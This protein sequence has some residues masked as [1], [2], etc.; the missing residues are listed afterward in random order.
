MNPVPT[1]NSGTTSAL[2][3]YSQPKKMTHRNL[4]RTLLHKRGPK[5]SKDVLQSCYFF[6]FG[7]VGLSDDVPARLT[8]GPEFIIKIALRMHGR[9]LSEAILGG[10]GRLNGTDGTEGRNGRTD[11]RTDPP[12][13]HTCPSTTHCDLAVFPSVP[14]RKLMVT[15]RGLMLEMTRLDGAPGSSANRSTRGKTNKN[16]SVSLRPENKV[17]RFSRLCD[18][19]SSAAKSPLKEHS[20]SPQGI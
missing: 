13:T 18:L 11:G 10:D 2:I 6:L 16:P 4:N 14:G 19:W 15:E 12:Q 9:R 3:F 1:H 20:P 17:D 5:L 7:L 8:K